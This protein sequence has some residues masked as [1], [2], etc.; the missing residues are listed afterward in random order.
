MNNIQSL[1]QIMAWRWQGDKPLSKPMMVRLP[2]NICVTRSQWV[3]TR[4]PNQLLLCSLVLNPFR[5]ILLSRNAYKRVFVFNIIAPRRTGTGNWY[6]Y[7]RG[8]MTT[9]QCTARPSV[10]TIFMVTSSNGIIFRVTGYLCGN[11]PVTGE[12]PHKG[13]WCGA[14]MFSLICAHYVVTV[15]FCGFPRMLL[16]THSKY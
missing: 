12:F 5:C 6:V 16:A 15:M 2:T 8:T 10:A 3:N 9:Y 13:Q 14:L 1:V 7:L 11:S 4:R